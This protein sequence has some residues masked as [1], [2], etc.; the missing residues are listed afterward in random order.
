[1][2]RN[3]LVCALSKAVLVICSGPE[4]DSDG[5]QSGTFDAGKTALDMKIPLFVLS[6]NALKK[7]II[8]NNDLI[9]MG[10]ISIN[11]GKELLHSLSNLESLNL[12]KNE[13]LK[14]MST[15]QGT[16]DFI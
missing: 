3:K 15:K 13:D 5:K 2:I 14:S 11:N 4:K 10:G 16:I 1:M 6:S 9:K 7:D 12:I 8:G